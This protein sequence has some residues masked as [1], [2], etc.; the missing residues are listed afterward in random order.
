MDT[1]WSTFSG[2]ATPGGQ[3]S[4]GTVDW[5]KA[6][7]D[8]IGSQEYMDAARSIIAVGIY[9]AQTAIANSLGRQSP[10]D[11]ED[12]ERIVC[13]NL[14]HSHLHDSGLSLGSIRLIFRKIEDALELRDQKICDDYA[15]HLAQAVV[16]GARLAAAIESGD[17]EDKS[18]VEFIKTVEDSYSKHGAL[19]SKEFDRDAKIK[20]EDL[21][22]FVDFVLGSVPYNTGDAAAAKSIFDTLSRYV[23]QYGVSYSWISGPNVR[24][25]RVAVYVAECGNLQISEAAVTD[26]VARFRT[27]LSDTPVTSVQ[28]EETIE[29]DRGSGAPSVDSFT[30]VV[31]DKVVGPAKEMATKAH[32]EI[33]ERY[34]VTS[35]SGTERFVMT[36][37]A[38]LATIFAICACLE[39]G[40][41][42]ASGPLVWGCLA[43]VAVLPLLGMAVHTAIDARDKKKTSGYGQR[44]RTIWEL[45]R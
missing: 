6:I 34:M 2:A 12:V 27:L 35:F 13:D 8:K 14:T 19:V 36:I 26:A 7:S 28:Q 41:I 24:Y 4:G 39:P 44:E 31:R 20:E 22:A 5:Q 40:I 1:S 3:A 32:R 33:R 17:A 15:G 43:L 25:L 37:S 18:L 10:G 16:D 45:L 29:L 21:R 11:C 9:A 42:G 38:L 30:S 23:E